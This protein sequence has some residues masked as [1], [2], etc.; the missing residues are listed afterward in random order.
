TSML[1]HDGAGRLLLME[2]ADT[3]GWG[4]PGGLMEPGESFEETGRR[5]VAEETGLRLGAMELLGVFAGPEYYYRYPNGDEIH[6]VTAAYVAAVTPAA[7]WVPD[8]REVLALRFF[9]LDRLP[10]TIIAPERPIVARYL[11]TRGADRSRLAVGA[12]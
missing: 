3:G 12:Q 7:A 8:R 4:L 2:R 10:E 11:A 6:N 1:V 9:P 5:E